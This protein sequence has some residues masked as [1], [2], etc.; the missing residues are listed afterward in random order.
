[1]NSKTV[2]PRLLALIANLKT[3]TL[4]LLA[5]TASLLTGCDQMTYA[6]Q[7]VYL[8]F[9]PEHDATYTAAR[10]ELA[11]TLVA[12]TTGDPQMPRDLTASLRLRGNGTQASLTDP[13]WVKGAPRLRVDIFHTNTLATNNAVLVDLYQAGELKQTLKITV[14]PGNPPT[15]DVDGNAIPVTVE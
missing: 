10:D 1:M 6:P 13:A 5:L 7:D 8:Q 4:C 11:I 12:Q 2:T 9:T 14:T 3:L 15:V